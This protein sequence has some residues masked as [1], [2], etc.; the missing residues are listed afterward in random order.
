VKRKAP[1]AD[2][3]GHYEFVASGPDDPNAAVE[4]PPAKE[5]EG[6]ATD[7]TAASE[8]TR[9]FHRFN[10]VCNVANGTKILLFILEV[11]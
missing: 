1:T 8:T 10:F 6:P 5:Q 3:C 4:E 11:K 2:P 7:E 9:Y